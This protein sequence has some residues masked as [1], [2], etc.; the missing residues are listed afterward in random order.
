MPM[1]VGLEWGGRRHAVCVVDGSG[2]VVDRFEAAHDRAGLDAL[3]ARLGKQGAAA[4]LPVAIERPSG[5]V[6]DRLVAAG[7]A[8]APAAVFGVPRRYPPR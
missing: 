3:L 6:V 1:F 4:E 2:A 7:H 5:L 8:T